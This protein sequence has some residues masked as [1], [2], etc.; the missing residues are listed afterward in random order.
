MKKITSILLIAVMLITMIPFA[1]FPASATDPIVYWDGSM[2]SNFTGSGT[3]ADPYQISSGADLK[4]LEY[5]FNT[6][7]ANF[8][9]VADALKSA[10]AASTATAISNTNNNNI[11]IARTTESWT[12]DKYFALTN[13]IYLNDTTSSTWYNDE[14]VKVSTTIGNRANIVTIVTVNGT[15]N[16][17]VKDFCGILDGKGYFISGMCNKVANTDANGGNALFGLLHGTIKNL[18]I[19]DSYFSGSKRTASFVAGIANN[20]EIDNC[21]SNAIVVNTTQEA[22]GIVGNFFGGSITNCVFAG[23]VTGPVQVGGILGVG[24]DEGG[25]NWSKNISGNINYGKVVGTSRSGDHGAIAGEILDA[26]T[27]SVM[28][29]NYALYDSFSSMTKKNISDRDIKV[30]KSVGLTFRNAATLL[31]GGWFNLNDSVENLGTLSENGYVNTTSE[32]TPILQSVFADNS[33]VLTSQAESGVTYWNGNISTKLDGAGTED[34]PFEIK[35]AADWAMM[36]KIFNGNTSDVDATFLNNLGMTDDQCCTGKYFKVMNNIYFNDTTDAEWYNSANLHTSDELCRRNS[37]GKN[38]KF[39]GTLDGNGK[40]FYGMCINAA[41]YDNGGINLMGQLCGTVQNLALVNCRFTSPANG[42]A[43]GRCSSFASLTY[44]DA[45][46]SNCYS[47]ATITGDHDVGGIVGYTNGAS[48]IENCV[49]AGTVTGNT[50]VGAISGGGASKDANAYITNCLVY[51]KAIS[52]SEVNKY[53]SCGAVLGADSSGGTTVLHCSG[54]YVLEGSNDYY[55]GT[56]FGVNNDR[57]YDVSFSNVQLSIQNFNALTDSGWFSLT[58]GIEDLNGIS[59]VTH[60][61]ETNM[62]EYS[63][64]N[65]TNT[66]SLYLPIIQKTFAEVT[67]IVDKDYFAYRNYV[68]LQ[69]GASIRLSDPTGLRF[70]TVIDKGY[71][72]RLVELKGADNV[73]VGTI[74]CPKSYYN[75]TYTKASLDGKNV[76]NIQK[77]SE[78]GVMVEKSATITDYVNSYETNGT[79]KQVFAKSATKAPSYTFNAAI[80]NIKE[81]NLSI[82]FA[83]LS[84]ITVNGVDILANFNATDNVRNVSEVATAALAD[85]KTSTTGEYQ[86]KVE[87]QTGVYSPYTTAQRATLTALVSGS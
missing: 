24:Q 32:T 14:G 72:D 59:T 57:K 76:I 20:A 56:C 29:N 61:S 52:S 85:T 74:I 30:T 82:D 9:G 71:Y 86:Y 54:N 43:Y 87:G 7:Q 60:N 46:I 27:A 8:V 58:D 44:G 23:S 11:A 19:I 79:P 62:L 49:F 81:A 45:K 4:L 83:A 33:V 40:A 48:T 69:T 53:T 84:Y 64:E 25:G 31:N 22:G 78:Y 65:Y 1:A 38:T 70:T 2:S 68:T 21:F 41:A 80:V 37:G 39:D 66:N 34:S 13:N 18:A 51:G 26:K 75:D 6:P 10:I 50:N 36:T 15:K 77:T 67:E 12:V 55:I 63:S 3:E 73:V 17:A 28:K 16:D 42:T 5:I 35:S 47:N